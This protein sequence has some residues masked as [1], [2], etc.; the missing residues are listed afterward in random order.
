MN[1]LLP[2]VKKH[3][4]KVTLKGMKSVTYMEGEKKIK[5]MP[6]SCLLFELNKSSRG[7]DKK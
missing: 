2:R 1:F 3:K 6:A 5:V 4:R 7:K